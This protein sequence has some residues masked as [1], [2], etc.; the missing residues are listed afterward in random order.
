MG[1]AV[2]TIPDNYRQIFTIV[3]WVLVVAGGLWLVTGIMGYLH[4]RAYNLT[5]AESSRSQN[6]KPDFL[7]VNKGAREDAIERGDAFDE[8]L[9][10][11]EGAPPPPAPS[12]LFE[13]ITR[14]ATTITAVFGLIAAIV[15]TITKAES[16][17]TGLERVGSWQ[18]L[19]TIVTTYPIGTL[20]VGIVIVANIAGFYTS[21]K[22]KKKH[23]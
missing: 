16:L 13:R 18:K 22:K 14:A 20:L 2:W 15:G 17:Q 10:R 21:E 5:Y 9:A 6:I 4:R 3:S 1:D 8:K 19:T 23:A 7:K 12:D 11:R